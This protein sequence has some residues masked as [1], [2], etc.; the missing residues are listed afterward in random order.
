MTGF[1][2]WAVGLFTLFLHGAMAPAVSEE[3]VQTY[4]VSLEPGGFCGYWRVVPTDTSKPNKPDHSACIPAEPKS[5]DGY[6]F[7]QCRLWL[8]EGRYKW[9]IYSMDGV[10]I[11]FS[12]ADNGTVSVEAPAG[13]TASA[14]QTKSGARL[15]LLLNHVEV[16]SGSY[17]GVWGFE[18]IGTMT[19]Q[20]GCTEKR[21]TTIPIG[22]RWL[23]SL[24][25]KTVW[26][27]QNSQGALFAEVNESLTIMRNDPGQP[28]KIG[29][30]TRKVTITPPPGGA[31]MPWIISEGEAGRPTTGARMLSLVV[32]KEYTIAAKLNGKDTTGNFHLPAECSPKPAEVVMQDGQTRFVVEQACLKTTP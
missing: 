29:L 22:A 20:T 28:G 9:D 2:I 18:R 11:H 31:N 24:G 32:D 14:A 12:V 13:S 15:D 10:Q 8:P 25:N 19:T 4:P 26:I 5:A 3:A 17:G 16:V 30:V 21:A 23:F 1:R 6:Y 7:G 27:D